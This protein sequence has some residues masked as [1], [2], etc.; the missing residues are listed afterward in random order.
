MSTD[1]LPKYS[2]EERNFAS[3]AKLLRESKDWSQAEMGRALVAKGLDYMNQMTVSRIEKL[4]RPVRMIEAQA[5]SEV[6]DVSIWKLMHPEEIDEYIESMRN[7]Y[8]DART[9]WRRLRESVE[10]WEKKQV[11]IQGMAEEL[12]AEA[13]KWDGDQSRLRELQRLGK[14]FHWYSSVDLPQYLAEKRTGQDGEHPEA[15]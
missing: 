4:Q 14:A 1:E 9:S 8:L 12:D 6:F 10:E 11:E 2:L 15:S 3:A 5:Y 7:E 13:A